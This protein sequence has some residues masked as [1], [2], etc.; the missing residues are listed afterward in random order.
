[1]R[2]I[3]VQTDQPGVAAAPPEP[4]F[5][6]EDYFFGAGVI[7]VLSG[8]AFIY[9]PAAL[10]LAGLFCFVFFALNR[11]VGLQTKKKGHGPFN[12]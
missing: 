12:P 4:R 2:R 8:V 5:D 3:I 10:I 9:W 11:I 6:K 1:M 7:L